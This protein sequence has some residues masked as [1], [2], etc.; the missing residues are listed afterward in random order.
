MRNNTTKSVI[1]APFN[2]TM[3]VQSEL[4]EIVD[5][6]LVVDRDR[7]VFG[8]RCREVN[9]QYEFN[10]NGQLDNGVYHKQL[11]QNSFEKE[12]QND[13]TEGIVVE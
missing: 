13:S 11:V 1:L 4:N 8:R 5:L 7:F 3:S 10:N 9:R 6:S 2:S 12:K